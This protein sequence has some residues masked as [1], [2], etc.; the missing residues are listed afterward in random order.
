MIRRPRP[1][2][3]LIEALIVIC[4]ITVLMA[5]AMLGFN[6]FEKVAAERTTHTRL[7]T[8]AGLLTQYDPTGTLLNLEGQQP[9]SI[10]PSNGATGSPGDVNATIGS[11]YGGAVLS[12]A[13][14][15]QIFC[16]MPDV[17]VAI[18]QIPGESLLQAASGGTWTDPTNP[19]NKVPL[20]VLLDGWGNPII[21][22]PSGG[23][24]GVYIGGP[25]P[26]S[27]SPTSGVWGK[28]KTIRSVD[29]RPFWASAGADGSFTTGDDN[30]YSCP[31][32]IQ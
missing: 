15:F 23:L 7:Q 27:A 1:G 13:H 22:V 4:V 32:V 30:V 10:Y 21:Y 8:C 14:I 28:A 2:F 11:R 26:P 24:T 12:T 31:V 9:P 6:H 25:P 19:T 16:R 18:T 17:R 20:T 5:L 3:T 29:G